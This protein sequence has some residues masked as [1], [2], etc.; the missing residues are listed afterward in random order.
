M[1]L[2][3]HKF[4]GQA[5]GSPVRALAGVVFV[6]AASRIFGNA[7]IEGIVGAAENI[8]VIHQSSCPSTRPE[9]GLAQDKFFALRKIWRRGEL[10]RF[11]VLILR[12]LFILRLVR[13]AQTPQKAELRYTA[14][15]RAC[16]VLLCLAVIPLPRKLFL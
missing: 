2:S 13:Y 11:D 6:A 16:A 15:I 4:D 5:P 7:D 1:L 12:K 8:A 10:N 14:A 9:N 3:P